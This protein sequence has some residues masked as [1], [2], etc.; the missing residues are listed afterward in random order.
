MLLFTA[1]ILRNCARKNNP[2][3]LASRFDEFTECAFFFFSLPWQQTCWLSRCSC[4]WYLKCYCFLFL[5]PG[6][7]DAVVAV[8]LHVQMESRGSIRGMTI[9]LTTAPAVSNVLI[10]ILPSYC[11]I[12]VFCNATF[13][14]QPTHLP[15]H[16]HAQLRSHA[17]TRTLIKLTHPRALA[18]IHT[19][20]LANACND[21][22]TD[23][24]AKRINL[25]PT[26][27]L[28]S[29]SHTHTHTRTYKQSPTHALSH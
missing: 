21:R 19:P 27:A 4:C 8:T 9:S 6:G 10:D 25:S 22:A 24:T 18:L 23:W 26:H 12:K 20:T 11:Y 16:P 2:L 13:S 14:A 17:R 1:F 28:S 3:E 5:R 29:H 7:V 15:N